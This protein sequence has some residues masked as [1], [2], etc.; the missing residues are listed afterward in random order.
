VLVPIRCWT[1][2]EGWSCE[3]WLTALGD[4]RAGER[5]RC[6][7]EEEWLRRELVLG[8]TGVIRCMDDGLVQWGSISLKHPR[9]F[10]P[11]QAYSAGIIQPS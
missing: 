4:G 6:E 10:L 1:R 2:V 8:I 7:E 3:V 5:R 11:C 9:F